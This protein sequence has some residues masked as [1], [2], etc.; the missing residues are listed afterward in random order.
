MWN[1]SLSHF[2]SNSFLRD[3]LEMCASP[4]RSHRLRIGWIRCWIMLPKSWA[5][6]CERSFKGKASPKRS[7]SDSDVWWTFNNSLRVDDAPSTGGGAPRSSSGSW[8]STYQLHVNVIFLVSLLQSGQDQHQRCPAYEWKS[9]MLICWLSLKFDW[10]RLSCLE[11]S[12]LSLDKI[13]WQK[14][15]E[16]L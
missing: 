7:A 5:S 8:N 3:R 1:I 6:P 2:R 11:F 16:K 12:P 15:V 4:I 9:D 10:E 14:P 13:G